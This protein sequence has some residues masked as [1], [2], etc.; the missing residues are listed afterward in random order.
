MLG[1][2]FRVPHPS[3][4][5]H[6]TEKNILSIHGSGLS[7]LQLHKIRETPRRPALQSKHVA[8]PLPHSAGLHVLPD[9]EHGAPGCVQTS[10]VRSVSALS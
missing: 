10:H 1:Q 9:G 5:L 8:L 2:S 4:W 6:P 3:L 7:L